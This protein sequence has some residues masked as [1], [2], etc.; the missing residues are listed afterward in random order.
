MGHNS[1][2]QQTAEQPEMV[3][4]GGETGIV[5]RLRPIRAA[6]R[7]EFAREDACSRS[8]LDKRALEVEHIGSTSVPALAAKPIIDI[9]LVVAY[10]EDGGLVDLRPR[11]RRLRAAFSG[12]RASV[13]HRPQSG[14]ADDV[15][16]VGYLEAERWLILGDRLRMHP[17]DRERTKCEM[18]T[19]R[20]KYVEDYA[21][22]KFEVVEEILY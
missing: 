18:A 4:F 2:S 3:T 14:C 8:A 19:R 22:A 1:V 9:L 20:Q 5:R 6:A 15:V 7:P 10:G 21:D 16:S 12:A 17:E 13:P 11:D